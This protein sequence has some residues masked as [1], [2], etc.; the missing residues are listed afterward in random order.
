M[1]VTPAF[2]DRTAC[3]T[4]K[5]AADPDGEGSRRCEAGPNYREPGSKSSAPMCFLNRVQ[6]LRVR[7]QTTPGSSKLF[8]LKSG[9]VIMSMAALFTF[10]TTGRGHKNELK[11]GGHIFQSTVKYI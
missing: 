8:A 5:A 7:V 9:C 6:D 2:D 1:E 4:L 10:G 3:S 11:N